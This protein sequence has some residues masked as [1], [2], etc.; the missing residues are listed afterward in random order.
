MVR[1]SKGSLVKN[2][3][4]SWECVRASNSA[5]AEVVL[6]VDLRRWNGDEESEI[7]REDDVEK[8]L[9]DRDLFAKGL[10]GS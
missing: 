9:C 1:S 7:L 3:L 5:S 6:N 10:G 8:M 4:C 2:G